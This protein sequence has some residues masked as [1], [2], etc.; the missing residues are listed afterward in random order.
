MEIQQVNLG[1]VAFNPKGNWNADVTYKRLNVVYYKGRSYYAKQ[2][3]ANQP[4]SMDSDFWGLMVDGGDVTNNPDEEDVTSM[5]DDDGKSVIKFADR[6]YD[7]D[8]FSGNGY[9]ILR[10]NMQN[11]RLAV[12]TI[13]VSKSPTTDGELFVTIN[14]IE[15]H[16][17]LSATEQNTTE[18]TAQAIAEALTPEHEDYDVVVSGSTIKLTRKFGGDVA[19]STYYAAAE[20]M[21]LT[22]E[23]SVKTV[24]RN[25]ITPIMISKANTIYEIRY[26]FDLNGG[27]IEVPDNCVL[28]FE[29]GS[30]RNG[31]IK[32]NQTDIINYNNSIDCILVGTV[33][34]KTIYSDIVCSLDLLQ[35]DFNDKK[36]VIVKNE[37]IKRPIFLHNVNNCVVNGR[38]H[39]IINLNC[40]VVQLD[41]QFSNIEIF[42]IIADG[43]NSANSNL[44]SNNSSEG[45]KEYISIHDNYIYNQN[46]GISLNADL[47]GD[48]RFSKVY[49]NYLENIFGEEIGNGY[50]IHLANVQFSSIHDNIIKRAMRHSIYHAW[51]HDNEIYNNKI[52]EH[53][54]GI[55]DGT[56]R[57]ALAIFRNSYNLNVHHNEFRNCISTNIHLLASGYKGED[58]DSIR[59][60]NQYNIL[61]ESNSFYFDLDID[62][63]SILLGYNVLPNYSDYVYETENVTIKNNIFNIRRAIAIDNYCCKNLFI[64]SNHFILSKTPY[65]IRF[66]KKYLNQFNGC[67]TVSNNI[68]ECTELNRSYPA[69][70]AFEDFI[71]TQTYNIF[72]N[73]ILGSR[74]DKSHYFHLLPDTFIK[75]YHTQN[76]NITEIRDSKPTN[77]YYIKGDVIYTYSFHNQLAFYCA[78]SGT[79]GV[80]WEILK[81]IMNGNYADIKNPDNITIPKGVRFNCGRRMIIGTS[82]GY[83]DS[84]G[85]NYYYDIAGNLNNAPTTAYGGRNLTDGSFFFARDIHKPAWWMFNKWVDSDGNPIDALK[86]GTTENRPT[87]TKAGYLYYDTTLGK[88]CIS[89]GDNTW[90]VIN[91][92]VSESQVST[93]DS[94]DTEE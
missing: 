42:N 39:K 4:P 83:V 50:G 7:P 11:V 90:E 5:I 63:R 61:I 70:Y 30:L 72:G 58:R 92:I 12:V 88:W 9:K 35:I 8:R 80:W 85:N 29:G 3:N 37:T 77:G 66:S 6:T 76:N 67:T 56:P 82:D 75:N 36:I 69:I 31:T 20:G 49:N 53:R 23:D 78:E 25:L 32:G 65:A 18:L 81:G 87:N 47:A 94:T 41:G 28:K 48:Y 59:Y 26:D 33:K 19:A 86:K 46:L 27:E 52:I 10:K 55:S 15:T 43:K 1:Q 91:G 38:L 40:S 2:E 84:I 44:V 51:G 71:N 17:E 54:Y 45:I 93:A 16:I 64:D 89:N 57:A 21:K 62:Y 79:P 24:R 68:I 13:N 73:K 34:N 22:V 74:N 60:G 14:K